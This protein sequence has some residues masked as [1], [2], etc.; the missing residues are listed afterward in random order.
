[1]RIC[2]AATMLLLMLA[3]SDVSLQK[4]VACRFPRN[5]R[6]CF[7]SFGV[8]LSV[9]YFAESETF[10]YEVFL[11]VDC[12][13][14]QRWCNYFFPI[15]VPKQQGILFSQFFLYFCELNF[16]IRR[17]KQNNFLFVSFGYALFYTLLVELQSILWKFSR[18]EKLISW[19]K[20]H[21]HAHTN[22]IN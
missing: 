12:C 22:Q 4:C 16:P 6:V 15:S 8:I 11:F 3:H 17:K 20:R 9:L 19:W 2:F 10:Y 7:F 5:F 14:C 18:I 1:M 21:T 13:F